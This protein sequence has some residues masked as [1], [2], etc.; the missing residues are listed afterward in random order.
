V[1]E[2]CHLFSSLGQKH[3]DIL[4]IF[5]SGCLS[6]VFENASKAAA[7]VKNSGA[8]IVIDSYTIGAGLGFLIQEAAQAS[9]HNLGINKISQI[10]RGLIPHVYTAMFLPNLSYLSNS[11]YLD[12]AQAIVGEMIGIIPFYILDA[13]RL[14]S[15]QKARNTRQLVDLIFEFVT[16]F[17]DVTH[18]AMLQGFPPYEQ[19]MRSLRERIINSLPNT[20]LSEHNLSLSMMS[21]LGPNILGVVVLEKIESSF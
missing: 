6:P 13:G 17:S 14:V 21:L 18:I 9:T 12:P 7:I 15:V 20:P 16:E 1:E 4:A 10:V 3:C 5:H 19:E 2:F 8:I 11:G